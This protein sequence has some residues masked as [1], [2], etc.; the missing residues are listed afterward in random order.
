MP[1]TPMPGGTEEP[2][3]Q[4]VQDES[5]QTGNE[6]E[7]RKDLSI[8]LA[9]GKQKG[10]DGIKLTWLKWKDALG[11]EVH[12]SYCDGRKNYR[13]QKTVNAA[14]NAAAKRE[15]THMGLKE[16]RA[17]KYYI[18]AYKMID[19]KKKYVA[20]SPV[21]HVAMKYEERTNAKK[22][23]ANKAKVILSLTNKNNKKTFKI[24][25]KVKKEGSRKKLLN[26]AARLRYYTDEKEVAA[27]SRTGKITARGKGKCTVYVIAKNGVC[28]KITVTVK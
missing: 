27:V 17:Y 21:I 20:K 5:G 2:V 28:K 26:H 11:Y 1:E 22:I 4:S 10:R 3:L 16:N 9:T 25:V 8:L 6:I 14:V 12:W 15:Y 19:G 18:A 13:K 23:T 24:R 7:E